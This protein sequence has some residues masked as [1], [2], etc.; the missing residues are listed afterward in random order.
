MARDACETMQRVVVAIREG[1]ASQ[2]M[3]LREAARR[4]GVDVA[5]VKNTVD[6]THFPRVDIVIGLLRV[7]GVRSTGVFRGA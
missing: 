7:A 5:T 3:S 2:G 4:V 6:G 1:I